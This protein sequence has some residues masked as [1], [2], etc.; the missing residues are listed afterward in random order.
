M[1]VV[2]VGTFMVIG[3]VVR[4]VREVRLVPPTEDALDAASSRYSLQDDQDK[5]GEILHRRGV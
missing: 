2:H 1:A 4:E 5:V 3:A